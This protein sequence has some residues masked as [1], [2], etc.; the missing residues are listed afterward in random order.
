[1]E[2]DRKFAEFIKDYTRMMTHELKTPVS[3]IKMVL[4]LLKGDLTAHERELYLLNTENLTNKV[5]LNLDNILYM[6]MSEQRSLPMNKHEVDVPMFMEKLVQ[7]YRDMEYNPKKVIIN[8]F[9]EP[10]D[11]HCVMDNILMERVFC[12]LLENA[13]KYTGME[14]I[15]N[16]RCKQEGDVCTFSVEDNGIGMT[17][18]DQKNIFKAFE[19][20]TISRNN[21]YQGFGIGL[22]VVDRALKAHGGKI[23][24]KSTK[25]VGSE[26]IVSL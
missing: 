3:G 2:R 22:H 7:P 15:I 14:A 17:P 8:T 18:T 4:H 6:A 25:D 23:S 12:N 11:M 13:I 26:F 16:I 24:V 19:R 20:G 21:N 9:Y 5:I 10:A 1:M